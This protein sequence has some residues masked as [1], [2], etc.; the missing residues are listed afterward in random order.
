[1]SEAKFVSGHKVALYGD[2]PEM[3]TSTS[4]TTT[5][6]SGGTRIGPKKRTDLDR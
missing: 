1:M 2:V 4:P 5:M 6:I 3:N